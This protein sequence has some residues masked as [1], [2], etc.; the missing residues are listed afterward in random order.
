M[1]DFC[2]L[3]FGELL[4]D[5]GFLRNYE[6]DQASMDFIRA[7]VF[8]K[9]AWQL[10]IAPHL[11]PLGLNP[12]KTLSF[13]LA[14]AISL[15]LQRKFM[16]VDFLGLYVFAP[17][18]KATHSFAIASSSP[19]KACHIFCTNSSRISTT[20]FSQAQQNNQNPS[21]RDSSHPTTIR[22]STLCPEKKEPR[23]HF[24]FINLRDSASCFIIRKI[25]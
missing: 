11:V 1:Y 19:H 4:S 24:T 7:S 9:S 25:V 12:A 14:K 18:F 20:N 13:R 23:A 2:C 5:G 6:L 22:L 8:F 3:I 15:R 16:T 17:N 21:K 10:T